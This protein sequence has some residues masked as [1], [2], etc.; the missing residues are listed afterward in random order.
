MGT[1]TQSIC[2]LPGSLHEASSKAFFLLDLVISFLCLPS[3]LI[4]KR[5]GCY[6]QYVQ[7]IHTVFLS[8][9][10][11]SL[12]CELYPKI[13]K[14]LIKISIISILEIRSKGSVRFLCAI[15]TFISS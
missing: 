14:G 1:A 3:L 11:V 6:F 9:W 13:L 10:Q 15:I 4:D 7:R 12:D 5:K 8:K 2:L